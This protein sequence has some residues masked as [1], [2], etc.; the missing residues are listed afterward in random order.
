MNK[1]KVAITLERETLIVLD[2]LV[3]EQRFQSRSEAIEV[4]VQEKLRRLAHTRL[5]EECAKLDVAEERELAEEGIEL[6]AA[7]WPEY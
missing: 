1:A 7:S 4:A 2:R 6:E 3:A 5:A